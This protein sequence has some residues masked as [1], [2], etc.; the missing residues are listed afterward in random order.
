MIAEITSDDLTV[1]IL[2]FDSGLIAEAHFI[3]C[4]TRELALS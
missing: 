3:C 2:R 4:R 1:M